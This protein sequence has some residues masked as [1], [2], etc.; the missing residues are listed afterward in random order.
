MYYDPRLNNH[1]LPHDPFLATVIPRPIGWISTIGVNGIVNLAPYSCFNAVSTQPPPFVMFASYGRKDSLRNAEE[2]GEFV[3]SMATFE[4]RK[5]VNATSA[6][7]GPDV[8]EA[9]LARL[10]MTPSIGVRPPRVK[11]SPIAH[12]CKYIKTVTL[13]DTEGQRHAGALVIG[14]VVGIYIDD[15]I[16]VDGLVEFGKV[17]PIARL[18]YMDYTFVEKTFRMVRPQGGPS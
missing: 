5:E 9:E 3:A 8:S 13:E 14:Q 11:R 2:T 10:E 15:A 1:N 4:L 7:V 12:E 6:V 17:R 16:L 18:G